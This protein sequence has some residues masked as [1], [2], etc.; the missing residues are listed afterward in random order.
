MPTPTRDEIRERAIYLF[1]SSTESFITP[2]DDELKES[3]FWEQAKIDLMQAEG[4]ESLEYLEQM[5]HD[6]GLRLVSEADHDKLI[7]LER[8][9]SQVKEREQQTRILKAGLESI[10][11][12]LDKE[13][14]TK[15]V[16]V[17]KIVKEMRWRTR[18]RR[19]KRIAEKA[20]RAFKAG[21]LADNPGTLRAINAVLVLDELTPLNIDLDAV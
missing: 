15:T 9:L 2:E 20:V 3:G 13:G 19:K 6:I 16:T 4:T 5:A 14:K 8:R 7:D 21:K 12:D 18:K 11:T 17:E 10:K 1:Q